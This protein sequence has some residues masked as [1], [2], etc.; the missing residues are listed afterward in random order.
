MLDALGRFATGQ[1]VEIGFGAVDL[2]L[3]KLAAVEALAR[4]DAAQPSMLDSIKIEPNLWPMSAVVNWWSILLRLSTISSRQA[5]L[6]E[7]ENI[8]LARLDLAG[9]SSGF[10]AKG[11]DAFGWLLVT[12][13]TTPL[14]LILTA[15]DGG[16]WADELPRIM[17]GALA[18]QRRGAWDSTVS[19]AWGS[20]AMRKFAERFE[21][22][23]VTG[24]TAGRVGGVEHSVDWSTTQRDVALEFPWPPERDAVSIRHEGTGAPWAV[25]QA[26]AAIPLKQPLEAGYRIQKTVT[27][28]EAKKAGELHPGDIL[29][30]RLQVDA[31]RDMTWVV[32]DD[33]VP[34]GASHL[35]TGLA[36]DSEITGQS[37]SGEPWTGPIFVER[38][39]AA[40]R[41]YFEYLPKGLHA[42][43]YVIRL[44]QGGTFQLPSTRVEAL[45]SPEMFG[46]LPNQPMRVEP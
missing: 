29:R 36:R 3:R 19:N 15:L 37:D 43:E 12:A 22:E 20:V 4:Y 30:V 45:Y 5:R 26:Q 17:K 32:F 31:Q 21:S 18:R 33:P 13:D 9:T 14:R 39:F 41:A 44:N 11:I 40:V 8:L 7:A 24:T 16:V 42:F 6:D 46:E 28:V 34:A 38:S 10:S 35:G 23:K 2:P 25:I 1:L 27:A